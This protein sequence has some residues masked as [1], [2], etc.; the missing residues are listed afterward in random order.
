[1]FTACTSPSQAYGRIG[2]ETGVMAANPHRL[3][4]ML[5]DAAILSIATARQAMRDGRVAE[6]GTAVSKAIEIVANGLKA[7]LDFEAG[8]ELAP[9]LA[10]L[11]DYICERLLFA[12][13]KN[14]AAALDE[15]A[16]LLRELKGAWEEIAGD[17]AAVC[18]GGRAA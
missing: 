10:A 13:L 5:F 14:D 17:P 12:N 15:A 16:G 4:V 7:S 11:Y 6:K 8:S 2:V 9:R 3:I 18:A 1:M